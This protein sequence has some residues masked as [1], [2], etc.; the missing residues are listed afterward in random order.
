GAG[1]GAEGLGS[2]VFLGELVE[3]DKAVVR[4]LGG[5]RAAAEEVAA[6]VFPGV[7]DDAA[8]EKAEDVEIAVFAVD[9]GAAQFEDFVLEGLKRA[10]I[11]FLGA[12][13]AVCVSGAQ[14]GLHPVGSHD[15]ALMFD[16]EVVTYRIEDVFVSEGE[17]GGFESLLELEIEHKKAERLGGADIGLGGGDAQGVLGARGGPGEDTASHGGG[18]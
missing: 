5:E 17:V 10:Q 12:V 2:E 14:P 4:I 8:P 3:D 1:G 6:G 7:L 15:L 11:K 13:K 9:A 18:V 16:Q